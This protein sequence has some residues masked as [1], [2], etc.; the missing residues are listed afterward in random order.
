[1]AIA[2]SSVWK[3]QTMRRRDGSGE[4]ELRRATEVIWL[5][6]ASRDAGWKRMRSFRSV[7]RRVFEGGDGCESGGRLE[8]SMDS[9]GREGREEL[10]GFDE[11][12][13]TRG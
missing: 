12:E 13:E 3:E 1:M 6:I 10:F 7:M 11:G 4:K 5:R 2:S 8:R 9:E